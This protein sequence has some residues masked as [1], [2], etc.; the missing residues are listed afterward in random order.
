MSP[1]FFL[2]NEIRCD[3]ILDCFQWWLLGT[4][5]AIYISNMNENRTLQWKASELLNEEN[6]WTYIFLD[7]HAL[8]RRKKWILQS[9][10][11]KYILLKE[12]I[13][14]TTFSQ[15]ILKWYSFKFRFK[16]KAI[17]MNILICSKKYTK[18]SLKTYN[19]AAGSSTFIAKPKRV[20]WRSF[21]LWK[22]T[23]Y[24]LH[25]NTND[26]TFI[27]LMIIIITWNFYCFGSCRI[28]SP[29]WTNSVYQMF[30]F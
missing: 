8:I 29:L 1:N 23:F 28:F 5:V 11:E 19:F 15:D 4:C 16:M 30:Y 9:A 20:R 3:G 6:L 27:S 22:H 7:L 21:F 26:L 10:I 13:C 12:I 18:E 25:L 24:I 17:W 14:E 2:P